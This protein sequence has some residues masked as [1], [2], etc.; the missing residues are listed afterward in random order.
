MKL[1]DYENYGN[2]ESKKRKLYEKKLSDEI[3][4][5]KK[6][7]KK[8]YSTSYASLNLS[9][10]NGLI[11][12]I[13]EFGKG[14]KSVSSIYVVGIGGS[15]LGTKAVAEAVR[16]TYANELNKKKIYFADTTDDFLMED[17]L[18]MIEKDLEKR[19]KIVINVISKSGK[20]TET[21][22]NFQVIKQLLEKY[23]RDLS[24][25]VVVTTM[26]NSPL[27]DYA[28]KNA[29][30]SLK[31]PANVGGRY[32]VFSS[33]GLFP[34]FVYD[35][36]IDKLVKG[37]K[38]SIGENLCL[39][40]ISSEEAM[41]QYFFYKKGVNISVIF[42]FR[43][44]L[45]SL[46]KWYRQLIA[47]SLGKEK[48]INDK[49]VF[50]G[51]TPCYAIGSTDLH[52]MAQLYLG[53]PKD[54]YFKFI[55]PVDKKSLK[56]LKD[57][58]IKNVVEEIQG[59]KMNDVTKAIEKGVIG[60]FRKSKIPFSEFFINGKEYDLG[61]LMQSLMIETIFLGR[62]MNV[63]PFDQPS[64]EKYKKITRNELSK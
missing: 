2:L 63:N 52:S 31:I 51:L 5:I 21:I 18:K 56:I 13:K 4:L 39:K 19:K 60:A 44:Y 27:Y 47:E 59:K 9:F 29:I 6:E 17:I 46:G 25:D 22:A 55:L 34:L 24:K 48:S 35:I 10:D 15:N 37:A 7:M 41:R 28:V 58:G 54:K 38:E 64:V 12:L 16:G 36:D 1:K 14:Y 61:Y 42:L 8:D 26:K 23:D 45:E 57:R 11:E 43:P 62:L 20:T 50:R 32:S 40:S 30:P 33:V 3:D 53:G 49:Y